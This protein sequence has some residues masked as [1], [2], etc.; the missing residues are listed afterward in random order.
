[1]A[2]IFGEFGVRVVLQAEILQLVVCQDF[3]FQEKEVKI[4]EERFEV[5]LR[6]WVETAFALDLMAGSSISFLRFL[7]LDVVNRMSNSNHPG[8]EFDDLFSRSCLRMISE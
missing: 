3:S 1:M 4:A 7:S 5:C 2:L 6:F 8:C